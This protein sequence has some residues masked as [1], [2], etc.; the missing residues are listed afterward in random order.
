MGQRK[1]VFPLFLRSGPKGIRTPDLMAASHALYQLS[2][3]PVFLLLSALMLRCASEPS[4]HTGDNLPPS[5]PCLGTEPQRGEREAHQ[6]ADGSHGSECNGRHWRTRS[7]P[8]QS[9]VAASE[10]QVEVACLGGPFQPFTGTEE[11]GSASRP[12]S[13]TTYAILRSPPRT[14]NS[15]RRGRGPS[16]NLRALRPLPAASRARRAG[17]IRPLAGPA[18]TEAN[19]R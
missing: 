10:A 3:G 9:A 16:K 14:W 7:G 13:K 8:D 17:E 2:Y 11:I 6:H 15:N 18:R 12:R 5:G 19:A 1:E 4:S